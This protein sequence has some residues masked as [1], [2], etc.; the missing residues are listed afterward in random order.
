MRRF[1]SDASVDAGEGRFAVRL[2]TRPVRT[3]AG[4]VLAVPSRDLA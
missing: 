4:A 1:W 3:P 2:D